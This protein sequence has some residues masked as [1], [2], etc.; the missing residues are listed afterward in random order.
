MFGLQSLQGFSRGFLETVLEKLFLRCKV[1]FLKTI[2]IKFLHQRFS[3]IFSKRFFGK[4][5]KRPLQNHFQNIVSSPIKPLSPD[6]EI[7]R[8]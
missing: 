5:F 6:L 2:F 7:L 3:Q 4:L 8:P 1:D